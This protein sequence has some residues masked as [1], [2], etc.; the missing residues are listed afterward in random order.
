MHWAVKV[1]SEKCLEELVRSGADVNA[2]ERKSGRSPL[3]IAVEMD[4]LNMAISLVKKVRRG[5][6]RLL[7][8]TAV[9]SL[10]FLDLL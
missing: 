1:K 9:H 7:F 10:C 4:N 3:H 6:L 8:C 2:A 5:F